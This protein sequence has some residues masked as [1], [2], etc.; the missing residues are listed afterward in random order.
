MS[1]LWSGVYALA[2]KNYLFNNETNTI[3]QLLFEIIM[4][5]IYLWCFPIYKNY[6]FYENNLLVKA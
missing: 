1:K 6:F 2:S 5:T 3:R 4:V